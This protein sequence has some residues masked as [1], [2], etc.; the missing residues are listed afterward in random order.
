MAPTKRNKKTS[1][2]TSILKENN[3]LHNNTIK[4]NAK[5]QQATKSVLHLGQ[6]IKNIDIIQNANSFNQNQLI[7][8]L[9]WMVQKGVDDDI[10]ILLDAR[11]NS[12]FSQEAVQLLDHAIKSIS[13]RDVQQQ[14]QEFTH[15]IKRI[16]TPLHEESQEMLDRCYRDIL[17]YAI[18]VFENESNAQQW[19]AS[20]RQELGGLTPNDLIVTVEGCQ[21][22]KNMLGRIDYGVYA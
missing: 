4:E 20:S 13:D 15:T 10:D 5:N 11:D 14:Q 22:V 21:T 8:A 9:K 7:A 19:L 18:E 1:D 16:T 2:S 17:D 12:Q 6:Q 3:S